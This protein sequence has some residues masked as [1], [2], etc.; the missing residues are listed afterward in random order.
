MQSWTC[1]DLP[2]RRPSVPNL[3][4]TL[5]KAA[6]PCNHLARGCQALPGPRTRLPTHDTQNSNCCKSLPGPQDNCIGVRKSECN[7]KNANVTSRFHFGTGAK[8]RDV[9][10]PARSRTLPKGPRGLPAL[11][12]PLPGPCPSFARTLQD[13]AQGST[14]IARTCHDLAQGSTR[15]LLAP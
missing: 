6:K 7:N 4:R 15:I 1:Q 8:F 13:L 9:A 14:R 2:G 11:A 12:P 5:S 3:A 10:L